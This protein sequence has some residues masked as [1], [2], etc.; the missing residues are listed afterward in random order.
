MANKIKIVVLGAIDIFFKERVGILLTSKS[1]IKIVKKG[2]IS[3][4]K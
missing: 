3:D 2:V 1:A 4:I